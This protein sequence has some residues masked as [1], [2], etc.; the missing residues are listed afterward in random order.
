MDGASFYFFLDSEDSWCIHR[1]IIH[2]NGFDSG[3]ETTNSI[4][5]LWSSLKR[6]G[7]FSKGKNFEYLTMFKIPLMKLFGDI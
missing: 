2:R 4:E 7:K 1:T 5:G 6:L 3:D